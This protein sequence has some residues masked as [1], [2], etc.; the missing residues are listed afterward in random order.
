MKNVNIRIDK[1]KDNHRY[2]ANKILSIEEKIDSYDQQV[3][4]DEIS[5]SGLPPRTEKQKLLKNLSSF[6]SMVLSESDFIKL[7]N[8][9]ENTTENS[10]GHIKFLESKTRL[11]FM[12]KI[13][14]KTRDENGKFTPILVEDIF[15]LDETDPNR[16]KEIFIRQKLTNKVREILKELK[17]Q[18]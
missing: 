10:I 8:V 7:N 5:I 6:T 9:K 2:L 3:L 1:V 12:A 17:Q 14:K 15:A 13:R 16:G 18:V 4:V 11:N